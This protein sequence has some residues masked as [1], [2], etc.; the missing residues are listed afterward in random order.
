MN[1]KREIAACYF[2]HAAIGVYGASTD[3][4]N[5]GI[6]TQKM[7]LSEL[8][9]QDSHSSCCSTAFVHIGRK[10][11]N[12]GAL[13]AFTHKCAP[14]LSEYSLFKIYQFVLEYKSEYY[15]QYHGSFKNGFNNM[16]I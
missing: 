6:H 8:L 11:D 2:E 1:I 16:H 7:L 14:D 5:C 12:I 4:A 3:K 10:V 15:Q 9:R 13:C